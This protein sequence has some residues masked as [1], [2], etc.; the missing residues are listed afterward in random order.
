MEQKSV[1]FSQG[2][3]TAGRMDAANPQKAHHELTYHTP[4]A[5]KIKLLEH[6]IL[7]FCIL[8]GLKCCEFVIFLPGSGRFLDQARRRRMD[9][10][11]WTLE[12]TLRP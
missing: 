3:S 1:W 7:L 8:Q 12:R 11:V 9:V 10:R 5:F 4:F 2:L 6:E